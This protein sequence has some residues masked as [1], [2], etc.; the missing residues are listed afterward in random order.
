MI[1][2]KRKVFTWRL[3]KHLEYCRMPNFPIIVYTATI[4]IGY[5]K[6]IYRYTATVIDVRILAKNYVELFHIN[7]YGSCLLL[8]YLDVNNAHSTFT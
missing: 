3:C 1:I 7:Y 5:R 6:E 8:F 4:I 2:L